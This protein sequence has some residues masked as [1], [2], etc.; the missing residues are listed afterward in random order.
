MESVDV[1]GTTINVHLTRAQVA[2][3]VASL[4]GA[5]VF[6]E[7]GTVAS[8]GEAK[9]AGLGVV[10][11]DGLG[12][13]SGWETVRFAG[14]SLTTNFVGTYSIEAGGIGTMRIIHTL[15]GPVADDEEAKTAT[16]NYTF[17]VDVD[18][19]K[20]LHAIR[21]ENGVALSSTFRAR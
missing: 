5:Y 16:S 10:N 4:K 7:R 8:G 11:L 21:T 12:G 9:L 2:A 1:N 3:S 6:S 13:V 18:G 14:G 17:L 19:I 15:P 20:E